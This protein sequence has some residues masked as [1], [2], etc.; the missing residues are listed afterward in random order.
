M[1]AEPGASAEDRVSLAVRGNLRL[2]SKRAAADG[3]RTPPLRRVYVSPIAAKHGQ[4]A[5]RELDVLCGYRD[6]EH[7]KR[8]R[9]VKDGGRGRELEV[10]LA[11]ADVWTVRSADVLRALPH[12]GLQP[13]LRELP[14]VP[15][16]TKAEMIAWR[17]LWPLNFKRPRRPDPVLSAPERRCIARHADAVFELSQTA[18]PGNCRV[19]ALLV[20]P[21]SNT[22]VARGVDRSGRLRTGEPCAA[23][24]S[25]AVMECIRQ[26]SVPHSSPS[27]GSAARHLSP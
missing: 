25:H 7:L 24:I 10:V 17:V 5:M 16:E 12:F 14:A 15:P 26:F 20:H 4:S 13:Q 19:A 9:R 3:A 2:V 23:R 11:T 18:A 22:V 1:T 27:A 6:L 8:I 21:E